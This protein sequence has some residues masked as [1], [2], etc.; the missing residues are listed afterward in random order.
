[1]AK[2]SFQQVV[3]AT[4]DFQQVVDATLDA[5]AQHKTVL[6]GEATGVLARPA[7]QVVGLRDNGQL[8]A[9]LHE[10]P[11]PRRYIRDNISIIFFPAPSGRMRE[12]V[13]Q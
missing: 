1:L 7:D 13:K 5:L 10:K 12:G 8:L 6:G 2:T 9:L 4:L 11:P 3:E